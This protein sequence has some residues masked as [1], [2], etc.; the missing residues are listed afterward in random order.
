MANLSDNHGRHAE[1]SER[2]LDGGGIEHGHGDQPHGDVRR[3]GE[4]LRHGT[5]Q[6]R[7]SGATYTITGSNTGTLSLLTGS[8]AG[9][10]R[11][12]T[13]RAVR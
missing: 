4:P 7:A 2:D 10:G 12:P 5:G 3:H 11:S 13:P 8:F 6:L 9:M 1:G